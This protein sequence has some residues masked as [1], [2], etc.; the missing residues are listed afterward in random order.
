MRNRASFCHPAEERL[1]EVEDELKEVTRQAQLLQK[2]ADAQGDLRSRVAEVTR[3]LKETSTTALDPFQMLH[4]ANPE[5][6]I[7]LSQLELELSRTLT[8][9]A[10]AEL[11][12]QAHKAVSTA[13]KA[14]AQAERAMAEREA[15]EAEAARAR[16]EAERAMAERDT[17]AAEMEARMEPSSEKEERE[18][19][20][21]EARRDAD[22]ARKVRG[23]RVDPVCSVAAL[24]VGSIAMRCPLF[25]ACHGCVLWPP[26]REPR[27]EAWGRGTTLAFVDH[28]HGHDAG[29]RE[30]EPSAG[31]SVCDGGR[32]PG[33]AKRVSGDG[34]GA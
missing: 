23:A 31:R 16:E 6:I 21:E 7:L 17:I 3:T 14:Q 34:R 12:S 8:P 1:A 26:L 5:P 11:R 24:L 15:M 29:E 30:A 13:E 25:A 10:A 27:P 19:L 4:H 28:P 2:R 22:G 33:G 18:K 9:E 20:L 32:S